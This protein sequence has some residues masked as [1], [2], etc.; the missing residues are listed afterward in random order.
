LWLLLPGWLQA[1]PAG[2]LVFRMETD[3]VSPRGL[4]YEQIA[5]LWGVSAVRV[6]Q[7]EQRALVKARRELERQGITRAEVK[8]LSSSDSALPGGIYEVQ[9]AK[10]LPASD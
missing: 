2:Q 10:P 3:F 9:K 1:F 5:E 4:T 7:I 6:R 8:Q